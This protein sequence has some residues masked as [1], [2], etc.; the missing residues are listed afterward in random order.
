MHRDLELLRKIVLKI[1]DSE[2]SRAP[3]TLVFD[4]YTGN[5]VLY[6]SWLLLD[7]GLVTGHEA[8]HINSTGKEALITGLTSK[9]HDFAEMARS[10]AVW[11]KAIQ[12]VKEVSQAVTIEMFT[13][14]LKN[15]VKSALKLF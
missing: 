13:Q 9:G 10:D 8:T 6:H 2:S 14:L 1:E 11:N 15:E 5:Q 4:G 7:A 12:K 3:E